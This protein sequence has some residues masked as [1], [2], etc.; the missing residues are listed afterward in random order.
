MVNEGCNKLVIAFM[1]N[2]APYLQAWIDYYRCNGCDLYVI[3]NHSSDNTEQILI[4]NNVSY[5]NFDTGNSFHL[6]KLQEEADRVIN[7]IK[8]KW[9]VYA[10][11]DLYHIFD[12]KISDVLDDVKFSQIETIC[13]NFLNI[14]ENYNSDLQNT[15]FYY[16]KYRPLCLISKYYDGFQLAGDNITSKGLPRGLY[17]NGICA[18]YGACKSVFEQ[19]EKLERRRKAWDEGLRKQTGKHFEKGLK[20]NWIYNKDECEDIRMSEYK[21]LIDKIR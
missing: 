19:I 12:K 17:D 1:Y 4:D 2:E 3:N 21:Y 7:N 8:P 18:N 16:Q 6:V 10:A 11:A 20:R 13:L 5:H 9:V 14:G 15:Y